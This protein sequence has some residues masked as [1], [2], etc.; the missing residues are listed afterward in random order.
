MS[1]QPP[2]VE[3]ERLPEP[4]ELSIRD[5]GDDLVFADKESVGAW[6]MVS[7]EDVILTENMR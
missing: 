5:W 4:A 1:A 7:P 6:I 3:D 2:V